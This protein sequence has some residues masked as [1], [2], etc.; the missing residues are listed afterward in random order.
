MARKKALSLP[1]DDR[2]A[3]IDHNTDYSMRRQCKL[4]GISR[5]FLYYT[6]KEASDL[7]Q[8]VETK[9]RDIYERFPEY[10]SPRIT[11]EL[12]DDDLVVNEKRVARIMRKEGLKAITPGPHTSTPHPEHKV[13]PYLLRDVEIERVNQVWSTDIT[14]IRMPKGFLYLTA[15]ID[16]KSRYIIDWELSN[17]LD[18]TT[19]INVLKRALERGRP[20]VFNTDQGAQ[21]TSPRFTKPL[22][23]ADI[24]ISMDGR[25]RAL[26]N[27]YIERFWWSLKYE[28]IFPNV[29]EDG[30]DLHRGISAYIDHYNKKR[31]HSSLDYKT[32]AEVYLLEAA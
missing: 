9:I 16:W 13:Y 31:K 21:F 26:D 5:S 23:D 32:P 29:Y 14:Y 8:M 10:G 7:D 20:E 28:N 2:R 17:T 11:L 30:V 12:R 6:P 15:I 3:W 18:S 25:G 1:V 19:P 24:K 27:V 4:A 22:L